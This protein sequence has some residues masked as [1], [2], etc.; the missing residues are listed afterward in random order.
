MKIIFFNTHPIQY[1][2]PLYK[3]LNQNNLETEAWYASDKGVREQT[4][5][6]FGVKIK[7]DIPVLEGYQHR[8][9]KNYSFFRKSTFFQYFNPG[10]VNAMRKEPK[11]VVIIHGW[12]TLSHYL[13]LFA[14]KVY[15]HKV[16]IRGENPKN[17]E[18]TTGLKK[19]VRFYFLKYSVFRF[20]DYALFIGKENR[21]FYEFFGLPS[22]KL[23]HVP[24]SVDNC[25]LQKEF[26]EQKKKSNE[27]RNELNIP[28]E[29][30]VVL[31][32]GK[33]IQKKRPMDLLRAALRLEQE[34]RVKNIYFVFMGEGELRQCMEN[35]IN[36]NKLQ[37]VVLTGFV[38]QSFINKYYV[39]A[40]AFVMCSGHGETWG[41]VVNEAMNFALPI[42]T[43]DVPGS[44]HDLVSHGTNGLVYRMGDVNALADSISKMYLRFKNNSLDE[45]RSNSLQKIE[46][47][48][49]KQ[50]YTA[51]QG[52]VESQKQ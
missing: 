5:K 3:H 39:I 41:L 48:S 38:N 33:Y 12:N 32:A 36:E 6:E 40:D 30:F 2:G 44:A 27:F 4:D 17:Q 47:Y 19:A 24:Y 28:T 34:G 13:V 50:I 29:A 22:H 20:V 25:R 10:V 37:N 46:D 42:I 51:L 21:K 26:K 9:F 23:V 31:F 52:V 18:R 43:S 35:F 7:W 45:M 15:G 1:F 14:A 16:C 49:Y 11:S 8:F